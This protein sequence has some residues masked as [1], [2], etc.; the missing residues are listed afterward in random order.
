MSVPAAPYNPLASRVQ[1]V[2][3]QLGRETA[4]RTPTI[5]FAALC[6]TL[7]IPQELQTRLLWL[8]VDDGLVTEEGGEVRLTAS[9]LGRVSP[10]R[11]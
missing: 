11:R 3:D 1:I 7:R 6:R 4:G 9:G 2:L 8:L 10:G 5:A